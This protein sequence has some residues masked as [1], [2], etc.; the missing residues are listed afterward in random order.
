MWPSQQLM[1]RKNECT[2]HMKVRV[3]SPNT[4]LD[5]G[6]KLVDNHPDLREK[7]CTT[8]FFCLIIQSNGS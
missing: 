1:S 6:R 7:T 4:S 8:V 3:S 5:S 2:L